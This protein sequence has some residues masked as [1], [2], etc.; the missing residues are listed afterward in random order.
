[1]STP[2]IKL[3]IIRFPRQRI[4]NLSNGDNRIRY[5]F[6]TT[7]ERDHR[8]NIHDSARYI[9]MYIH[10]Y[11]C[12]VQIYHEIPGGA[13]VA[14]TYL[15]RSRERLRTRNARVNCA[16]RVKCFGILIYHLRSMRRSTEFMNLDATIRQG[17][18]SSM[19]DLEI[20]KLHCIISLCCSSNSMRLI[21]D[22]YSN[23]IFERVWMGDFFVD[24][25]YMN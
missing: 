22:W 3:M 7:P 15:E 23:E 12:V 10:T 8:C 21:Y 11:L 18:Y 6:N 13:S 9:Y 14:S 17:N 2:M 20:K 24:T 19:K 4:E 5:E 1:M 16:R 25:Y